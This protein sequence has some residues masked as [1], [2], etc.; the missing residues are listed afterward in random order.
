MPRNPL[1]VTNRPQMW[2]CAPLKW[3]AGRYLMS[4][5][6]GSL[7]FVKNHA[8]QA[9]CTKK[10]AAPQPSPGR[11]GSGGPATFFGACGKKKSQIFCGGGGVRGALPRP[12]QAI[13]RTLISP[14][15]HGTAP[16]NFS[17]AATLISLLCSK[18]P[19][20]APRPHMPLTLPKKIQ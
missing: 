2:R 6:P 5:C 8:P 7:K 11:A 20:K 10:T 4:P 3:A 17:V 1:K 12:A 16:R 18:G 15:A 14:S 9:P 13:C 19:R